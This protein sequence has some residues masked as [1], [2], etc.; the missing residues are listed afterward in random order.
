MAKCQI[1]GCEKNA[2]CRGMCSMHY[3]RWQRHGNPG[4]AAAIRKSGRICKVEV[5][6]RPSRDSGFCTMHAYRWRKFRDPEYTPVIYGDDVVRFWSKVDKAG[7]VSRGRGRCWLWKTYLTPD[8]YG[9]FWVNGKN[10]PAHRYAYELLVGPIP[11]GMQP[12]HLCRNRACVNP[13]HLEPVT[14]AENLLRGEG[15]AASNA[16]K[17]RC[18][19]GHAFDQTNT[20]I[21]KVGSRQCRICC[22]EKT[23][24]YRQR[25]AAQV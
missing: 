8:G 6:G 20:L 12:D 15:A 4:R 24:R 9:R 14:V 3:S 17:T 10:T 19:R 13:A 11:N 25:K 1:E 22:R 16:R 5:C 18:K 2:V 23:R 7:P 21:T